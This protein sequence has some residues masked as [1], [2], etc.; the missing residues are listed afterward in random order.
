MTD[1]STTVERET[2]RAQTVV[3]DAATDAAPPSASDDAACQCC[4]SVRHEPV[5]R[6]RGWMLRRCADCGLIFVSPQ[7]TAEQLAAIYNRS[8]GYFATAEADLS[9]TPPEAAERLHRCLLGAAVEGRRF[10]DVGCATGA[11]V[12]HMARLGWQAAGVDVNPDAV[13]IARRNGLDVTQGALEDQSFAD[14]S[15]DVIH[16]GDVLEHLR[17]PRETLQ[18]ARQLLRPGGLLVVKA[19]NAECGFARSSLRLSRW[20]RL[21]W[22][23]SAAPYHLHEFCPETLS[24]LTRAAGLEVSQLTCRGRPAFLYALGA[25]GFFDELKRRMKRDGRYRFDWRLIASLPRLVAVA[26]LLLPSLVYGALADRC[27]GTGHR[28]ILIARRPADGSA[29]PRAPVVRDGA[30]ILGVSFDLVSLEQALAT[31][32]WWRR[33]G[34]RKYVAFVNPHSVV[35]SQ[36]GKEMRQALAEA[37]LT[38]PDGT[39]I[40]WAA[41]LLGHRN[42]GRITGP[43]FMLACCDWGRRYGYRHYFCGGREGVTERLAARLAARFPGLQVAGTY[44][45]PFQAL[46]PEEDEGVVAR[47]NAARPDVVWIGLGAPKQE[48]WMAARAGRIEATAMMGVGAAFDFHTGEAKW[49]PRW[50]RRLGIEWAYRLACEPRRLWRRNLD[51][52]R[53]LLAVVRQRIRRLFG[54]G[55]RRTS[56]HESGG[57]PNSDKVTSRCKL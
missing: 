19:P 27:R 47:I 4:G 25:S 45:P 2:T 5:A 21:P 32:E 55:P 28:M 54:L 18:R 37:G 15:F 11:L 50:V 39:G 30:D 41:R 23:W 52:P 16:M 12:H 53:F 44:C 48:R 56:C 1:C 51:S 24:R 6:Q 22:A 29:Q 34:E 20:L 49:A 43:S 42:H 33:H 17:R 13:A 35:M 26:A 9:R 57:P 14:A 3:P 10:L 7:P 38:L 46:S 31:V 8:S 40:I 36:R